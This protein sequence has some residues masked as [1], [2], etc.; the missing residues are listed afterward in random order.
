MRTSIDIPDPLIRR[1]KKLARERGISLRQL[2]LDGLRSVV[3]TGGSA[4]RHR[5]NDRSFGAGGLV[6]GLDWSD[7]ER[8]HTLVYGGG[9]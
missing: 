8:M 5:M 3:E 1:A 7:S 4:R 2:L 6:E 9:D